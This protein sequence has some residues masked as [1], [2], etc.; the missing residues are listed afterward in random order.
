MKKKA[1]ISC[2]VIAVIVIISVVIALVVNSKKKTDNVETN[3][4]VVEAITDV[5]TTKED[6]T[7]LEDSEVTEEVVDETTSEEIV[8]N[9]STDADNTDDNK[10]DN[11]SKTDTKT[12]TS[13]NESSK[14][15]EATKPSN[16]T[17][18]PSNNKVDTSKPST[19]ETS[20]PSGNESTKPST[21]EASKP[22]TSD[23]CKHTNMSPSYICE[24]RSAVYKTVKVKEQVKKSRSLS[25]CHTCGTVT[26]H[27][28]PELIPALQA[29]N[30]GVKFTS[31]D[32]NTH[33]KY[34]PQVPVDWG[35]G[36]IT[37]VP[38][39]AGSQT[40]DYTY[41][42]TEEVEKQELVTPAGTAWIIQY[43][44][45]LDCGYKDYS[46]KGQEDKSLFD[47]D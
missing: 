29:A 7:T 6:E 14:K 39:C 3:S 4:D 16:D 35:D 45:C 31:E 43:D 24:R 22:T 23:K 8:D 19:T 20:K 36:T 37:Y 44:E 15:E 47:P 17:T 33:Q 30:P 38:S 9:P 13:K 26:C 32:M 46:R 27:T 12:E 10:S 18:K 11:D 5:S 34:S 21:T 41:Y 25:V 1:L 40:R 2:V 28:N 42:V